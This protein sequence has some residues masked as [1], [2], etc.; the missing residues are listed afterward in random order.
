MHF[1]LPAYSRT[2][3]ENLNLN[4]VSQISHLEMQCLT[5]IFS[6][7]H[8]KEFQFE[9]SAK[10]VKFSKK[11]SGII[12]LKFPIKHGKKK[13]EIK[14][15]IAFRMS[16]KKSQIIVITCVFSKASLAWMWYFLNLFFSIWTEF[17]PS[18]NCRY[19]S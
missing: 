8:Y 14:T 17:F 9:S 1:N 5:S 4:K 12:I 10:W 7:V 3:L 19:L 11:N 13:V 15:E 18:S 6:I 2:N 16:N